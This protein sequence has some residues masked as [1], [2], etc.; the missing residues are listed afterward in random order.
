MKVLI[1]EDCEDVAF[2]IGERL[3]A[4]GN[5]VEHSNNG[6]VGYELARSGDYDC[7]V[8]DINLPDQDGFQILAKLRASDNH[9]PIL[10][11]TARDD[12]GDKVD[13]LDLGADD[14]MVKPFALDELEARLRAI[15]RRRSG[16]STSILEVGSLRLDQSQRAISIAGQPIDFGSREVQLLEYLMQQQGKTVLKETLVSK[17]F[18]YDDAGSP[19][20]VELL[21]SRLRKKLIGAGLEILTQRG[22][23]YQ[24]RAVDPNVSE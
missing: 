16:K 21:V 1:I 4:R 20:A 9:T 7:L 3:K 10:V 6:S 18:G 12:L 19:N 14:Y 23:G 8:L 13:M 22:V 17:L 11:L 24:L 15:S 2:A 5:R